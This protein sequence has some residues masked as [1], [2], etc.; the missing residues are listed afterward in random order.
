MEWVIE[1]RVKNGGIHHE[2]VFFKCPRNIENESMAIIYRPCYT[3]R[4]S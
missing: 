2:R 4:R 3:G 1:L